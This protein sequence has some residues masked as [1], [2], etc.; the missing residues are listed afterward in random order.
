MHAQAPPP[1]DH[2]DEARKARWIALLVAGAFFMENL[3]GTVITTAVPDIAS[4]FGVA[5]LDLNIGV[6]AY[7]LTLGVFIPISGWVADRFGARKVF[8]AALAL[9][10]IASVLCGMADGLPEFVLLRALQGVGGA[11]MVPVGRLVVLKSTPKDKLISVIATLTWP[12]LVA[13]VL[14]PPLG[15]FITSYSS[16]RWIF[17]LNL[18]LGLL[19]LFFAWRLI[20]DHRPS[21]RKPFDAVGFLYAGGALLSLTW[22]AETLSRP[23]A[24]WSEAGLFFALG[25][26]LGGLAV[27]RLR[28]TEHP[29][30]DLR[31]LVTPTFAVA[32]YGGSLFR[33]AIG[34]VPF[35]LPLL[36]QVGFGLNAFHSGMMVIAVF[37]GNLMM[38]PATTGI[39]RRF[40]FKP[41]L[42]VNGAINVLSLLACAFLTPATPIWLIALVLFIGGLTRSMQFTAYNTIAFAD[43]AQARMAAANTLFSTA[44]QVAMGL[45][46]A[47]GALGVRLGHWLAQTAGIQQMPAAEFRLAFVL[48]AVV[49]LLG[50]IDT[51]RLQAGSGDHLSKKASA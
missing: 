46:V 23:D 15:G 28:K 3:D 9:F 43:M 13:P 48:V 29:L 35:L 22:A 12:A 30:I 5:P 36:F 21:E 20:P 50:M 27:R 7:L 25:A 26:L 37:A 33:M 11:M 47:L 4:S 10:T 8:A 40:G 32:I 41:V 17:Y 16:W 2:P 42:L 19:A 39:L 6:S 18:P 14:G 31:T 38:K 34:A 49:S 24:P 51:W 44:F 1:S 45:G